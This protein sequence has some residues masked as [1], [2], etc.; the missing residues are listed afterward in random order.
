MQ[1]V[2]RIAERSAE[3]AG[4]IPAVRLRNV[5][6]RFG[7]YVA[8]D[9]VDLDVAQGEFLSIVGPTGCGKSTLLNVITGLRPPSK[10]EVEILGEPLRDLNSHSGYMLQQDALLPWK[11]TIDNVALG[12]VFRGVRLNEARQQARMWLEKVGLKGFEDRFPHQ[13][14]G[15]MKKRTALAQI[16][17]LQPRMIL[18][19]EPFSALDVHT[20]RLMQNELLRLWSDEKISVIFITHDLEEAIALADRVSVMA[21]GPSSRVIG[22][23]PIELSRPRDVAEILLNSDFRSIYGEIW[24]VLRGEVQKTYQRH[25]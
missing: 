22:D 6:V 18:L 21:A 11:S 19:D 17:I 3:A 15:G 4:A 16:F 1:D 2:S 9:H 25:E 13:L 20:R 12:L 10:G 7:Q 23:F 24:N 14:S 5:A 8:V